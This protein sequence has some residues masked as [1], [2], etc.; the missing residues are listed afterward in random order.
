MLIGMHAHQHLDFHQDSESVV[1]INA[2]LRMVSTNVHNFIHTI[3]FP[4]RRDSDHARL[5]K[6]TLLYFNF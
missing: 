1:P 4:F 6:Y 2:T 3:V 5:F